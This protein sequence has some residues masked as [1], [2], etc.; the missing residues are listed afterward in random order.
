MKLTVDATTLRDALANHVAE[1][2]TLEHLEHALLVAEGDTLSITTTD[3]QKWLTVE[4]DASINAPGACTAKVDLLRAALNGLQ[5]DTELVLDDT[6]LVLK[7]GRRRFRIPSLPSQ[8]FPMVPVRDMA[9]VTVDVDSLRN[10][11][12]RVEYAV[13]KNDVLK[14]WCNGV[15]LDDGYCVATSGPRMAVCPTE[16]TLPTDQSIILPR[17]SMALFSSLLHD[18]AQVLLVKIP[19]GEIISALEVYN[20]KLRTRLRTA[21]IDAIYGQWKMAAHDADKFEHRIVITSANAAAALTRTIPFCMSAGFKKD[22]PLHAAIND[23]RLTLWPPSQPDTCD[24]V[25]LEDG[26]TLHET[27]IDALYLRDVVSSAKGADI[28]WLSNDGI[29]PQA[30]TFEGRD[31]LHYINPMRI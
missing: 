20:Q 22:V 2:S 18:D 5:G 26:D 11:I 12:E 10:G 17:H 6:G 4:L 24:D 13:G 25:D 21:I 9:P 14:L 31:D 23:G 28:I 1:R 3:M 7:A 29:K 8:D 15:L 16:I 27:R 19:G 30:F